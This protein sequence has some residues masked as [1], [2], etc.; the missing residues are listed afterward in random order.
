MKMTEEEVK[1]R[2]QQVFLKKSDY[3]LYFTE[4][5]QKRCDEY[6]S[7]QYTDQEFN[8]LFFNIHKNK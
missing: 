2:Q 1:H 5:H 4:Q 3:D 6:R 7:G 8:Q